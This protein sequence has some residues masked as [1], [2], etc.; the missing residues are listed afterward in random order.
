MK[1]NAV[2]SSGLGLGQ[3]TVLLVSIPLVLLGAVILIGGIADSIR[4]HAGQASSRTDG[5]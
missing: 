2:A 4:Q 5:T 3:P 1:A